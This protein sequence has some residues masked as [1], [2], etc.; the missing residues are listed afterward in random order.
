M[1]AIVNRVEIDILSYYLEYLRRKK[2][3]NE[4]KTPGVGSKW[5]KSG[6]HNS[7]KGLFFL[8]FS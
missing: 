3:K 4:P 8:F 6:L 7:S 1:M 2:T 5:H